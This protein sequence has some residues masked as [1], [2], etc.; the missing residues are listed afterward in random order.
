MND[1]STT[2][3]LLGTSGGPIPVRERAMT[4]QAVVVDGSTYLVD[5]GGGTSRQIVAAGIPYSSIRALFI[6]HLHGDHVM[7]YPAT[8]LGGKPFADGQ[9]FSEPV[10]VYGPAGTESLHAGVLESFSHTIGIQ[11]AASRLGPG[12][13]ELVQPHD[14]DVPDVGARDGGPLAP[15][16]EPFVVFADDRVRVSAVLTNHPPVYPCFAFRFETAHGSA[17]VSGDGTPTDNTVRIARDADLLVHEIM[18][19]QAMLDHGTP[20]GFVRMLGRIHT[21]V[22]QVGRIA[23]DAGVRHLVLSH[24]IPVDL[25]GGRFPAEDDESW[26]APIRKDYDGPITIGTDL[27]RFMLR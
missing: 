7:D 11:Y 22:T 27:M 21:D 4:S 24:I 10:R 14:I 2:V 12:I 17:V 3:V 16:M 13:R 15:P 19:R 5:C 25:D 23:A 8:I 26:L 9:G 6:T 20:A 1:K 18:N